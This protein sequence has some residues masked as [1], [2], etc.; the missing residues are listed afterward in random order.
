[1]TPTSALLDPLR[2][3]LRDAADRAS[4]GLEISELSSVEGTFFVVSAPDAS[5]GT[6]PLA[7]VDAVDPFSSPFDDVVRDRARNVASRA[8][9][10]YI[11]ITSLRTVVVYRTDAVTRRLPVEQQVLMQLKGASVSQISSV[12]AAASR[13]TLTEG[14]RSVL[15]TLLRLPVGLPAG[16]PTGTPTETPTWKPTETPTGTPT[17]TPEVFFVERLNLLLDDLLAAT[18]GSVASRQAIDHL[19]T[20]VVSYLL[21]QMH[22]SETLDPLTLP[23]GLTHP[24]LMLDIIG[25]FLRDARQSG[26]RMFPE[27]LDVP[28]IDPQHAPLFRMALAELVSFV[29]SFDLARLD[30]SARDHVVDAILQWCMHLHGTP[31]PTLDAIDMAIVAAGIADR[32]ENTPLRVLEIG[33]TMGT[34]G[35]RTSL[36]TDGVDARV[37]AANADEQR[38]ILL[39]ASGQLGTEAPV[40]V[41]PRNEEI[42]HDWDVVCLSPSRSAA[43][44]RCCC[45]NCDWHP[46]PPSFCSFPWPYCATRNMPMCANT[47][48]NDSMCS[49]SLRRT[50]TRWQ[51]PITVPAA[52]LPA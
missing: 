24:Q 27:S 41:V 12:M 30:A 35:I 43:V 10:P 18:D 16:L 44:C 8:Q 40:R 21:V 42:D 52:S 32:K 45:I 38:M 49:G 17:G 29:Q 5:S 26:H 25:A 4:L 3:C 20:A 9:A 11:I 39:R 15:A 28:K 48:C 34:F 33:S 19:T 50:P 23:Y 6:T 2:S 7:I 1:M 46:M 31:V 37:Y 14:L 51:Y 47:W 13:I 36:V 22:H